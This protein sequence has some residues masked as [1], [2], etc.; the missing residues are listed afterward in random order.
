MGETAVTFRCPAINTPHTWASFPLTD[1]FECLQLDNFLTLFCAVLAERQVVL[2]S[3]QYS[4]L[5]SCAEA[6]NSLL[7]P[8]RWSHVYIPIL[9]RALL[10][11]YFVALF[12][13]DR[14]RHSCIL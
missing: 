5:T 1:I 9:P 13:Q 3:S 12:L 10:G 4:L 8:L 11:I 14:E 6:V 2:V 7:Y